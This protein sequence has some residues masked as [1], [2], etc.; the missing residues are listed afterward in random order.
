MTAVLND[1]SLLRVCLGD[2]ALA[3]EL[4]G[5]YR[6]DAPSQWRMLEQ[7]VAAGNPAEVFEKIHRIKGTLSS[8]CAEEAAMACAEL[9]RQAAAGRALS[10]VELRAAVLRLDAEISRRLP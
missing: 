9:E 3:L 8:L 4:L 1:D 2:E 7:A 6:G 10:L 5:L